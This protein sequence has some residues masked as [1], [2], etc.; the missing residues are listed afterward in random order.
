[1]GE[2]EKTMERLNEALA[3]AGFPRARLNPLYKTGSHWELSVV[4]DLRFD[5]DG[6]YIE[7]KDG[8]Y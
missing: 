7:P 5:E 6:K 8:E 2:I 4:S 3:G 1:M